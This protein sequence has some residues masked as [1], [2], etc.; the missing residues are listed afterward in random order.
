LQ[1]PKDKKLQGQCRRS[2]S[3]CKRLGDLTAIDRLWSPFWQSEPRHQRPSFSL[4][5]GDTTYASIN[6]P[7]AQVPFRLTR[8]IVDGMGVCGVHGVFRRCCEE[9]LAVMR[10]NKESLL[11][12]VEV[13]IHDP[14]YKWALSPLKALQRQRVSNELVAY[15]MFLLRG[16]SCQNGD[17]V[18]CVVGEGLPPSLHVACLLGSG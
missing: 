16:H 13:F 11:T 8:D 1:R 15:V 9:T 12:I 3:T 5:L 17:Q 2:T 6:R 7:S 10:A 4:L 14:L 18:N